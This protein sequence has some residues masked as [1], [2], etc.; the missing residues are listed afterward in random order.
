MA[1]I[2]RTFLVIDHGPNGAGC[3]IDLYGQSLGKLLTFAA[4]PTHEAAVEAAQAEAEKR[5][6]TIEDRT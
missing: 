3:V 2:K 6:C 5:G 4:R 1:E